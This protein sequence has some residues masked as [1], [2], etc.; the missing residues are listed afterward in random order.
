MSVAAHG[1]LILPN[2]PLRSP[3]PKVVDMPAKPDLIV[4]LIASLLASCG[5][6]TDNN[7]GTGSSGNSFG[8][9]PSAAP[10][11]L[12]QNPPVLLSTVSAAGL[13]AQVTTGTSSQTFGAQAL[14]Q[15]LAVSGVPTCDV[16]VFHIEYNTVG[17]ANEST[18]ASGALMVPSG[19]DPVCRGARPIVLY[20]HGT[21]TEP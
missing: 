16:N 7:S 11:T 4:V 5:G 19:T 20:A 18:T 21:T 10:G 6:N 17:G 12:V 3:C 13:L 8:G 14:T 2:L 9:T 15:V 1:K